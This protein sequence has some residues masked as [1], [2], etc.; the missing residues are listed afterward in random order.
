MKKQVTKERLVIDGIA[1]LKTKRQMLA[2][3]IIIPDARGINSEGYMFNPK[4]IHNPS[5]FVKEME[6][7]FGRTV[8]VYNLYPEFKDR[9]GI[10]FNRSDILWF[11]PLEAIAK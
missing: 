3:G 1:Q 8:R 11:W 9:I 6:E 7:Y 5:N 2:Q 10:S 4:K